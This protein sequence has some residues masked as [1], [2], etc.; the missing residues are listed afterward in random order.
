[1]K[2]RRNSLISKLLASLLLAGPIWSAPVFGQP[3]ESPARSGTPSGGA[4]LDG[5]T[6]YQILLGEIALQRGEG[7]VAAQAYLEVAK[8]SSDPAVLGRGMQ[9]A[10][11]AQRYDL[12][13]EFGRSWIAAEP[14]S[15]TARHALI[16]VLAALG[17]GEE[18]VSHIREWLAA[19]EANR[20]RN[21]LN[22]TRLFSGVA[23]RGSVLRAQ[24]E[25]LL[26]YVEIPE[27]HYVLAN[28]ARLA[29]NKDLALAEIREASRLRPDW[30]QAVLFEAQVLS[31]D[32]PEAAVA[33]LSK[34]LGNFH[35]Q[36]DALVMRGRLYASMR[37]YAESRV[38][39]EVALRNNPGLA[40]ALYPYAVV[41]LQQ[42]DSVAAE[43]VLKQLSEREIGGRDFVEFQLGALAEDRADY[44]VAINHLS[45]VGPGEY[46]IPAQAHTAQIL[47]RQGKV[48]EAQ[49][50]LQKVRTT[51]LKLS[52]ADMARLWIAEA[53]IQREAKQF[54]AAFR[55][56][57]S[58]LQAQPNEPDLLYDQAM[59]AERLNKIDIVESN[60]ARVIELKPDNAHAYN[61]LGYSL[62]D[63]NVR[64]EE[65]RSLI[66]KALSLAPDD[67]FIL[68]S[69]GWVLFR[70]GQAT[71]A[72]KHLERAHAMRKDPEIAAHLGE[73]L[74]VL[75]RRD[76]ARKVW[77]DARKEHPDNEVLGSVLKK[78]LP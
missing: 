71:E 7:D 27:A 11:A 52:A 62:A 35:E 4:E 38:D 19:D 76:E 48:A 53:A 33:V 41:L 13:L 24:Q 50:H 56:L 34:F 44:D 3:V 43:K 5:R 30:A 6:V 63:R 68:D 61:A 75:G 46:Y 8:R 47:A 59:V 18:M 25:L 78:F 9:I 28:S 26:P 32:S 66:V 14:K 15:P 55:T 16:G 20:P 12:A 49:A 67:P 65:A 77:Q 39:L 36:E 73:V 70:L 29:G 51:T 2:A 10:A 54:E 42:R 37:R 57:T 64:L 40:D 22:L 45:R 74:W 58:A 21:V 23:D 72:L 1:M 17:R 69:M 60:L 31:H